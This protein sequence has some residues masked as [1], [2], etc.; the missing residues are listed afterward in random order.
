VNAA[1]S[2]PGED[3]HAKRKARLLSYTTKNMIYSMVAVLVAVFAIWAVTPNPQG[4]QRRPA[5]ID[6]T[7][8]FAADQAD[9]PVWSPEG[10]GEGWSG[11]VVDY[12]S[13]QGVTTWRLLMVTPLTESLE[14]RQGLDP[15]S[16]WRAQSL[17][18]LQ[19]QDSMSFDTPAGTRQWQVWTGTSANDEPLVAVV[20]P[21]SEEQPATTIV[22]GTAE[23]SEVAEFI[24][25]LEVVPPSDDSSGSSG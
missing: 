7:S 24:D 10:L 22:D 1:S 5:E 18:G 25:A 21:P 20:L 19:Q 11:T 8:Q 12:Q 16:Q 23:V 2:P 3:P 6:K 13:R 4:P 9:W 14:L 17:E 15:S